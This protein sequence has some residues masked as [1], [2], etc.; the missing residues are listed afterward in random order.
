[1]RLTSEFWVHAYVRRCGS[2]DVPA[3]VVR[4]GDDQAGA[5]FI[6]ISALD[7]TGALYGPVPSGF[8]DN[9]DG[10]RR[11]TVHLPAGTPDAQIESHIE[12]QIAFDADLWVIE[13]EDRRGRPFLDGWLG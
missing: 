11:W 10:E 1:M 5:I 12:R 6:R 7:G 3:L 9:D 8:S 2:A 13:V 4:H